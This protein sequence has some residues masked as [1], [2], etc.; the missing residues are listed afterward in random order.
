MYVDSGPWLETMLFRLLS[1][2]IHNLSLVSYFEGY[3]ILLH[4]MHCAGRKIMQR[5]EE[6]KWMKKMLM[7]LTLQVQIE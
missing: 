4:S 5:V 2:H 1:T 3:H 6:R 7:S